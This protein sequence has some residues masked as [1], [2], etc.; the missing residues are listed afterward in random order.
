MKSFIMIVM[1]VAVC[2]G[3]LALGGLVSPEG[4]RLTQY[5][6]PGCGISLVS[7]L[8]YLT[9]GARQSRKDKEAREDRKLKH[10]Y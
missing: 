3:V 6:L 10:D 5:A 8:L 9:L 4:S 7:G 1:I 2:S